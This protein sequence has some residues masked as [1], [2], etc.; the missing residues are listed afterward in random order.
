MKDKYFEGALL[1]KQSNLYG[2]SKQLSP[3]KV[4]T[5]NTWFLVALG[6]NQ[7]SGLPSLLINMSTKSHDFNLNISYKSEH[8]MSPICISYGLLKLRICDNSFLFSLKI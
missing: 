3:L 4:N 6:S 5:I 8:F 7:L 1:S 2:T